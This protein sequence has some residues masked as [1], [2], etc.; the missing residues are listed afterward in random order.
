MAQQVPSRSPAFK[1]AGRR[2]ASAL[3]LGACTTTVHADNCGVGTL[4][5]AADLL[6]NGKVVEIGSAPPYLG[7]YR[8]A[9]DHNPKGDW[10]NPV[11]WKMRAKG[12]ST[13]CVV[14]A[15][16]PP[17][18]APAAPARGPAAASPPAKPAAAPLAAPTGG[19]GLAVGKYACSAPGAG[20][21]PITIKDGSTYIDRAGSSGR[22]SFDSASGRITFSSGSLAGQ[23]SEL[24]KP[25]KFGL[26]SAPTRQFYVVCNL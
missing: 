5:E 3:L 17:A 10:L 1:T 18:P 19:S 15:L 13:P 9:W 2:A 4:V 21:F 23:Y 12:S 26:S 6:P 22:Y 7:W 16:A 25:G 11:S 14:P 20:T 8:I 24:L